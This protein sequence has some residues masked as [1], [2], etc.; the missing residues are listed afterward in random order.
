MNRI[1]IIGPPKVDMVEFVKRVFDQTLPSLPS[2]PKGEQNGVICEGLTI[3]NKYCC[4]EIDVFIDQTEDTT[5][6]SY[7]ECVKELMSPE[8]QELRENVPFI[9]FI[10]LDSEVLEAHNQALSELEEQIKHDYVHA[11]QDA[12]FEKIL[13]HRLLYSERNLEKQTDELREEIVLFPWPAITKKTHAPL[14]EAN[15]TIDK[16]SLD[17]MR[18]DSLERDMNMLRTARANHLYSGEKNL[19]AEEK[20]LVQKILDTHLGT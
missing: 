4:I 11:N 2:V 1:L 14:G 10:Y 5:L 8:I 15:K 16:D 9:I 12:G 20:G 18:L 19:S 7:D 13:V 3:D 6:E 17:E